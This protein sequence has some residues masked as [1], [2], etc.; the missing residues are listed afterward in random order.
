MCKQPLVAVGFAASAAFM[1]PYGYQAKMMV[2]GPGGYRFLDYTRAG[3]ALNIV[4]WLLAS[5]P[6]P[7]IWKF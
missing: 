6:I 2:Y 4:F 1:T 7:L 3:A 5:V